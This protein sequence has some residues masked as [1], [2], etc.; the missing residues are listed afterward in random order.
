MKT[1]KNFPWDCL[2]S[3]PIRST[4]VGSKGT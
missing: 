4:P 1:K 3:W 2:L